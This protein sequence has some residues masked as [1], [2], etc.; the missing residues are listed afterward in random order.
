VNAWIN[1]F[2]MMPDVRIAAIWDNDDR[3]G[4]Q[5]AS[6]AGIAFENDLTA[7]LVRQDIQAVA[8]ASET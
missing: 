5:F 2:R 8:I 1:A 4:V 3:R 6:D 7:L